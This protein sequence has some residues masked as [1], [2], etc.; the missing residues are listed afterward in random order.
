MFISFINKS[1]PYLINKRRQELAR[2]QIINQIRKEEERRRK[3]SEDETRNHGKED[4]RMEINKRNAGA[5]ILT[6]FRKC[7]NT[8]THMTK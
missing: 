2:R 6:F 1:S 5:T 3:A 8:I 4:T 7:K